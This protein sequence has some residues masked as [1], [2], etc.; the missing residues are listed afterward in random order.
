MWQM[1][2]IFFIYHK[3]TTTIILIVILS[4]IY[5][6]SSLIN[7]GKLHFTS[8]IWKKR[9]CAAMKRR[10]KQKQNRTI[11]FLLIISTSLIL[12]PISML[13]SFVFCSVFI[14]VS[15]A[16]LLNLWIYKVKLMQ[17]QSKKRRK[18]TK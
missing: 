15:T 9:K 10:Q 18:K 11:N 12:S 13:S 4:F 7:N 5:L 3:I 8:E 2:N 17:N 16:F 1:N 14:W 6:F